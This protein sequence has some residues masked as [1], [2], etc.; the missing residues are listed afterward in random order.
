MDNVTS[1]ASKGGRARADALTPEQRSESAR[2]AV[3][4][5]WAKGRTPAPMVTLTVSSAH[6][7]NQE[8]IKIQVEQRYHDEPLNS[9]EVGTWNV[10][11]RSYVITP[12]KTRSYTQ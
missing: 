8:C 3:A 9:I 4:A 12:N 2:K 7:P 10:N 5:R 6:I 1:R 11:S